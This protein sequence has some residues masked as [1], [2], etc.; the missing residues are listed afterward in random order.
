MAFDI[1]SVLK[2][3]NTGKEQIVYLD[4]DLLDPDPENF[5]SLDG[6]DDLAGNIELIGLQQPLRVRPGENGHYIIISGHRRRAACMMIRD[7]GSDQ[8]TDGVP[9]IVEYGEA[10]AAMRELRLI[11][12]NA[13]TRMMSAADLSK[14]AERVEALLYELKEQGVEFPGRMRDHV[15]EACQVS[16]TKLARLHAIRSNLAPD[17]LEHYFDNGVINET[18]AYALSQKPADLQRWIVDHYKATHND[19][20]R[21]S[22]WWVRDF[23]KDAEGMAALNCRQIA[24]GG[25]C[26]H[27]REHVEKMWR[28][29]WRDYGGCISGDGTAK[30]CANCDSLASCSISCSRCDTKKN[31]MKKDLAEQRRSER[32]TK[33]ADEENRKAQHELLESKAALYWAR[34]GG[35]LKD[36]GIS[37]WALQ[38]EIGPSDGLHGSNRRLLCDYRLVAHEI[39]ALLDGKPVKNEGCQIPSPF[40]WSHDVKAAKMLADMADVLGVSIDYLM[41][42]TDNPN[43]V[44]GSDTRPG[45]STGTPAETGDYVVI[46]GAPKEE[47]A[48][49]YIRSIQTWTG[50]GWTDSRGVPLRLNVY[51]WVILPEV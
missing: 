18:S 3:T 44:S 2:T 24:G 29:G 20:A 16:K 38:D 9:C 19:D 51:R 8:F 11:Y 45:W 40:T 49:S 36:A 14:Q 48:G 4:L 37:F 47:T 10:S 28:R 15:A 21:V 46:C 31:R 25:E 23:A 30:C 22:E 27:Q 39:E 35:A 41:F 33:K 50:E 7:G 5:Y 6:L 32:E 34:L 26:I 1:T 17:L 42:R 13:A 12:A 43:P